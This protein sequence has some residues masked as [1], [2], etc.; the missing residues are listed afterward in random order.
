VPRVATRTHKYSYLCADGAI[1][2]V[3]IDASVYRSLIYDPAY[4]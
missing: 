4:E 3:H 2:E 1:S